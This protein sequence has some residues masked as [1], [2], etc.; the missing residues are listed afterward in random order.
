MSTPD[1]GPRFAALRDTY[2]DDID[3]IQAEEERVS[4]LLKLKAYAE[5]PETKML[6]ELC[7]KDILRARRELAT[8]RA[9]DEEQRQELWLLCDS[10]YWFLRMVVKDYAGEIAAIEAQIT[11]DLQP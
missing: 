11:S 10:R 8:N 9:L 7:R 4:N 3:K 1:F 5:L 2:P 6:M